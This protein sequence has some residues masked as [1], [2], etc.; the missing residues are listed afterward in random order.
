MCFEAAISQLRISLGQE[1]YG[2]LHSSTGAVSRSDRRG[3]R[4]ALRSFATSPQSAR[5]NIN[6]DGSQVEQPL[7]QGEWPAYT[8]WRRYYQTGR[9]FSCSS[10]ALA[11]STSSSRQLGGCAFGSIARPVQTEKVCVF[12]VSPISPRLPYPYYNTVVININSSTRSRE[13]FGPLL[14]ATQSTHQSG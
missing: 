3:G 13:L 5:H 1:G 2:N 9:T 7:A 4:G 11:A 10:T 14:Y 12:S 8:L 6:Q